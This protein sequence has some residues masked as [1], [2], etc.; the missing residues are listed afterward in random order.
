MLYTCEKH[1]TD[2][3]I[4]YPSKIDCPLCTAEEEIT[5]KDREI[6]NLKSQIE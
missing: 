4:V 2:V 3:V 6:D 5:D 1:G